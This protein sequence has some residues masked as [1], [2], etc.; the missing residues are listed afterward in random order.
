MYKTSVLSH[1]F[2]IYY[3]SGMLFIDLPSGRRL[4]YV[5]P[6]MG[7][8]LFDSNSVTYKGINT[9]KWTR[10]KSYG[11]KFVKNLVQAVSRYILAFAIK[12]LSHRSLQCVS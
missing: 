7:T 3:K 10:I 8:N 1:G 6:R 2:R 11:L 5:K 4:V 9:G 12:T